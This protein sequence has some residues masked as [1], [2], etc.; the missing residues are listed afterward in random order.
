M[1]CVFWGLWNK[2]IPFC[3]L[4]FS[5]RDG[6]D[7]LS[8]HLTVWSLSFSVFQTSHL[9]FYNVSAPTFCYWWLVY[10]GCCNRIVI[11]S[12]SVQSKKPSSRQYLHFLDKTGLSVSICQL[13]WYTPVFNRCFLRIG[14]W[15]PSFL[16]LWF[17]AGVFVALVMMLLSVFLLCLLVYNTLRQEPVEQQ[18]LTPVVI[19]SAF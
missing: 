17:T 3:Y 9:K 10:A 19:V 1:I 16:K 6:I 2:I 15:R 5:T 13:R 18:V 8:I 12:V 14:Q 4:Y 7:R 11:T